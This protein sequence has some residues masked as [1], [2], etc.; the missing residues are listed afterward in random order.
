MT[1]FGRHKEQAEAP[2]AGLR[3][4]TSRQVGVGQVG[5][6]E[7]GLSRLQTHHVEEIDAESSS[8]TRKLPVQLQDDLP[9]HRF[10]I[11]SPFLWCDC[12]GGGEGWGNIR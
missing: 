4:L 8:I 3:V 6:Q 10:Q 11:V 9:F 1:E 12:Q 7:H 2:D 5:L